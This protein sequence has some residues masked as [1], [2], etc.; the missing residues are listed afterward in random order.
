VTAAGVA[1]AAG[2]T[3]GITAGVIFLSLVVLGDLETLLDVVQLDPYD[4]VVGDAVDRR[5]GTVV[6]GHSM[7]VSGGSLLVSLVV[8]LVLKDDVLDLLQ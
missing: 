8:D 1:R 6:R 3:A 5:G 7:T 2:V 4:P